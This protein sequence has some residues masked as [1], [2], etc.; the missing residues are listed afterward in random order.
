MSAV[1]LDASVYPLC[2]SLSRFWSSELSHL[3]CKVDECNGNVTL[4]H[5]LYTCVQLSGPSLPLNMID[6]HICTGERTQ[7]VWWST[8]R[9]QIQALVSPVQG[10]RVQHDVKDLL[11][12]CE[13]SIRNTL[14]WRRFTFFLSNLWISLLQV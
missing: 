5:C 8:C 6:V 10:T 9:F 2:K 3:L 4:F 1:P 14:A 7:Q 12:W 13:G 11:S